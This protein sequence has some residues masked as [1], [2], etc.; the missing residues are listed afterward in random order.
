MILSISIF[1]NI[2]IIIYNL[3]YDIVMNDMEDDW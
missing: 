2:I 3:W 1:Y